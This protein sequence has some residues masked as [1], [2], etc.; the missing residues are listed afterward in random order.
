MAKQH[1]RKMIL[2]Q[3]LFFSL[4]T[5]NVSCPIQ[6]FAADNP[7]PRYISMT[8]ISY[9]T[10]F[11]SSARQ[12]ECWI[13]VPSS[14]ER[15]EVEILG[16]DSI[17]GHLTKDPK[18]QNQIYYCHYD[19]SGLKESDTI[20]I[21]IT[22]KIKIW[23]KSVSEAKNLRALPK[24]VAD[25][26]LNIYLSSNRLIP[27]QGP[28]FAL[29]QQLNLSDYPIPAARQIYEY[30]I[31]TMVYNWRVPGAGHGDAVWACNS[32]TGDC[33]DYNSIF[34]GVCRSAGIPAD[35]VFGLPLRSKDGKGEVNDWHCWGRFWVKGP[36]WITEDA[37]EAAK[38]PELHEYNFGT[39]SSIFLT[40]SHGRDVVLEPA[41]KE[42]AL[43]MFASPY[44]E[45]DGRHFDG[46]KWRVSFTEQAGQ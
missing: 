25:N 26:N 44:V 42:E 38:H 19:L 18:Y 27:L 28:I 17:H 33:S 31:S 21:R 15:Q 12:V 40:L 6:C 8:Y 14:D 20:K 24:V 22:Y 32:K 39:L 11:P 37:S 16:M 23:E 36:G 1:F 43:N 45:I 34:I 46:V 7:E 10:N 4:S 9:L 35:H 2:Y 5:L 13:P 41:Q 3:S 29:R 30:L